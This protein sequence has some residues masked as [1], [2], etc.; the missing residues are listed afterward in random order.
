MGPA[1]IGKSAIADI[2]ATELEEASLLGGSFFFSRPGQIDDPATVIPTLAYQLAL[3]NAHYKRIITELLVDD[4]LLLTKN[5][6]IQFKK[7]IVEPFQTIMGLD[8]STVDNPLLIILDG[9]D[10]CK[11]QWH[12]KTLVSDVDFLSTV[13]KREISVD[14]EEA[15]A[16][17]RC[18]LEGEL[19]KVRKQYPYLS[20]DWPAREDVDRLCKAASGHLGYASFMVR[21][22][23]DKET[24]DPERQLLICIRVAS[25]LGVD[26]GTC[27]NPLEALDCLYHRV[28]SDVPTDLLPT[29][30]KLFG[31]I[32]NSSTLRYTREF[33]SF[34]LLTEG[35]VYQALRQLHAVV[36]VPTANHAS[37]QRL[38]FFHASFS[39][40]LF[41]P[42]RSG[43][44][45][46]SQST[47]CYDVVVQSL[48]WTE[49]HGDELSTDFVVQVMFVAQH[50][51]FVPWALCSTVEGSNLLS[52]MTELAA[53]D[54]GLLTKLQPDPVPFTRFMEWLLVKV[55]S[56]GL[57]TFRLNTEDGQAPENSLLARLA[58]IPQ[59]MVIKTLL[60]E[61][62]KH[63][64][65]FS[66][67]SM[68]TFF[69][70]GAPEEW[71]QVLHFLLGSR[72]QIHV[73][74]T[75]DY[76]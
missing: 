25:G 50:C 55:S 13:E 26:Q 32:Q 22:I 30:M 70:D 68:S 40:F 35:Q 72:T 58:N 62:K 47:M 53:F 44:F 9:L 28:L 38:R 2:I 16:D 48:R 54:F 18:L 27:V 11:G 59:D 17:A 23:S 39:D 46:L 75:L 76:T 24:A 51:Q 15:I 37:S 10:E 5:R 67:V 56:L 21:F 7:L 71:P 36:Y 63:D 65:S 66:L 41:D 14:D 73:Q 57:G 4:P 8:S 19:A 42:I 6:A 43:K 49:R 60:I 34:L 69:P 64:F 31:V 61:L 45:H 52:L 12:L 74:L 33:A 1:A 20:S 3:M 29:A